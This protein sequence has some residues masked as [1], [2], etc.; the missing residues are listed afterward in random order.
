MVPVNL[1]VTL[2]KT[3]FLNLHTRCRALCVAIELSLHLQRGSQIRV[4][5]GEQEEDEALRHSAGEGLAC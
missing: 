5:A 4:P 2:S 3:L 1:Y